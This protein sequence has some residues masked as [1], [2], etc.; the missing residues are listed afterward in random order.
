MTL[1]TILVLAGIVAA[2]GTFGVVLA[3][4]DYQTR[5][6]GQHRP[7]AQKSAEPQDDLKLAA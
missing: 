6:L 3:W 1:A 4:A 5:N 7:G 2:F